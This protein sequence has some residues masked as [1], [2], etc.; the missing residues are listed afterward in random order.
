MRYHAS[1]P[2]A[3]L[4]AF[5]CLLPLR[6]AR[7]AE[8]PEASSRLTPLLAMSLE[9]LANL[10]V[11]L[12]TGSPKLLRLAPSVATVLTAADIET[13]GATTLDEALESVPGLHVSPSNKV[14]MDSVY[15]LRG[16]HTSFNSQMLVLMDGL[17]VNY[18]YSGGRPYGFKLP[19]SMISRIE[20]MRG[21][22]SAVYG[23]DAFA[24]TINIITKGSGELAGVRSGLR[25]GS[26][27]TTNFWLQQGHNYVGWNLALGLEYL[28][29][30]GDPD[31]VID[32]DL[33]TMLDGV[34]GTHASLAPGPLGTG[35]QVVNGHL[36]LS[37][38]GW[39]IRLWGW[40]NESE[41]GDGCTQTL[42]PA[43]DLNSRMVRGAIS[44]RT[45]ELLPET[46][47]TSRV[48]YSYH[49]SD[50]YFQLLPPGTVVPIGPDGNINFTTVAGITY[51][52][53]GVIGH[54]P[55][56]ETTM[57]IEETLLFE[58]WERQK[59]RLAAGFSTVTNKTSEAKNFG[60]GVLDGSQP[61]S[62]GQLTDVTGTRYIFMDDQRRDLGY[63]SLQDEWA[64]TD[65]WE[66]TG[67][68]RYD[69]YSDF[70]STVNPRL[71]LVWE[72][73]PELTT[74]VMYGRAF[75]PPAFGELYVKNNPSNQ[76]NP[77]LK[78][79]TID[80]YELAFDYRPR[81]GLRTGLNL[82]TYRIEDLIELVPDA[83]QPTMTARNSRDQK[84]RGFELEADWLA[85]PGLRLQGSA[86]YQRAEDEATGRVV[87]DAP[88]LQFKAS[89]T[90]EFL[91]EW[92][93]TTQ[94]HWIGDRHRAAGDSR[95]DI[96]DNQ[97]VNL[98]LR[99]TKIAGNW[100]VRVAVRNLFD[101]DIREPSQAVILND[102]PMEGR[103]FWGELSYRY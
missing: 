45:G 29:S 90:W 28:K 47:L 15:S 53:D 69:H 63:L 76:G 93:W 103:S 31:R 97:L 51:F 5:S 27:D 57:G 87:A 81:Q 64:L 52:P 30:A 89:A 60:P 22:G 6:P 12:A 92:N 101:E 4:V 65:G 58:G 95:P 82:F 36:G 18:A 17:P 13:M 48:N 85:L 19:V 39:D 46:T 77:D 80:T 100:D 91:P 99:R 86:A 73:L 55:G 72:T 44:H 41:M 21:P 61:L 62:T 3:L 25:Y 88:G 33:Q 70:G 49:V 7:A 42:A 54:P 96:K 83:G 74:K 10:E 24:G 79:E 59:W 9:E 8:E 20:V 75:R 94:Y 68:L 40:M 23:A 84:G 56:R 43:N 35:Y 38:G 71:A 66:L 50:T 67:G 98:T 11:S 26:F 37:K 14:M 16:I 1:A 102:Y 32:Q 34:F 2:L 78:P